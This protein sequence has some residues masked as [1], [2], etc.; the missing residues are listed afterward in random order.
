M[1]E[2]V[3]R[4]TQANADQCSGRRLLGL[5]ALSACCG[6]SGTDEPRAVM[7]KLQEISVNDFYATNGKVR[8]DGR[9]AHDMYFVQVKTPIESKG[10]WD[11]YKLLSMIPGDQA[12]QPL[13]ESGCPLRSD[14]LRR[15][16]LYVSRGFARSNEPASQSHGIL[17]E[18]TRTSALQSRDRVQ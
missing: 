6:G 14:E 4:A 3:L 1:V 2:A 8:K 9:L 18:L 5:P 17:V 13:N 12:F 16:A 10:P 7:A 15:P 11:Y